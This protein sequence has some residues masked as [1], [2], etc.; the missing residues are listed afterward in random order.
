MAHPA[1]GYGRGGGT[2]VSAKYIDFSDGDHATTI[3]NR[4]H[5]R[6]S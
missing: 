3:D 1:P 2:T 4:S 6:S 5:R